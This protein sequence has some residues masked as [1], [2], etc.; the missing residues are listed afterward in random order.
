MERM[1]TALIGRIVA[2]LPV[3]VMD[4]LA[5]DQSS[6][7]VSEVSKEGDWDRLSRTPRSPSS[8]LQPKLSSSVCSDAC[9]GD[10]CLECG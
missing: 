3:A 10:R 1:P 8:E 7:T 4:M 2:R 9:L 6:E 5:A